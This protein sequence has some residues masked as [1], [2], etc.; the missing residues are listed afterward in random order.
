MPGI[1]HW[2]SKRKATKKIEKFSF[3]NNSIQR[4]YAS[5]SKKIKKLLHVEYKKTDELE[6]SIKTVN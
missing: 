3:L 4:F 2:T 6:E 1:R 5:K